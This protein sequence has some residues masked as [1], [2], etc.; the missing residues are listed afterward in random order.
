MAAGARNRDRRFFT[1]M[2]IAAAVTVFVGFAP[3]YYLRG[4]FRAAAPLTT[5][6][7][8][9]PLRFGLAQ[10]DAWLSVARWLTE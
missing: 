8:S 6:V 4:V 3:T 2:A 10:T 1:W 5:L 7:H 9:L